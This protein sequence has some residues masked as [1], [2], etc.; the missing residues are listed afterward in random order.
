MP[1]KINCGQVTRLMAQSSQKVK[2][3]SQLR[4]SAHV[5]EVISGCMHLLELMLNEYGGFQM[6]AKTSRLCDFSI[7]ASPLMCDGPC[8]LWGP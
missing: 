8:L 5:R 2:A 3:R 4:E 6:E 7:V 1:L